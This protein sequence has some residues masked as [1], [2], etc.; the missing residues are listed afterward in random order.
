MK[1]LV[2]SIL[3]SV[4]LIGLL[5][6]LSAC[7]R[8]HTWYS[9]NL[10]TEETM[11]SF[12]STDALRSYLSSHTKKNV[13]RDSLFSCAGA[14]KDAV[15][16]MPMAPGDTGA[17]LD[18]SETNVQVSGIDEGDTVKTYLASNGK[19]YL[20]SCVIENEAS[21]II[22]FEPTLGRV[23]SA[24]CEGYVPYGF[25]T[26]G[27]K[28]IVYGRMEKEDSITLTVYGF[29]E[30]SGALTAERTLSFPNTYFCHS[31][32]IDGRVY[33]VMQSYSMVNEDG[34]PL[35]PSYLDTAEGNEIKL[36]SSEN[37]FVG[38]IPTRAYGYVYL[39]SFSAESALDFHAYI[40][41]YDEIYMSK[42]AL[43]LLSR[44]YREDITYFTRFAMD[45][46]GRLC[47]EGRNSI[48]GYISSQFFVDEYRDVF[49]A[50]AYSYDTDLLNNV[51]KLYTFDLSKEGFPL[52]GVS[53]GMGI[54][55]SVYSVRFDGESCYVTTAVTVDPLYYV[56]VSNPSAPTVKAELKS[57][58]VNDYLHAVSDEIVVGIGRAGNGSF[59][60]IKVSIYY[61]NA[62]SLK[63]LA[64]YS[65][66]EY[67][68][69]VEA[70]NNHKAILVHKNTFAF[71]VKDYKNAE[72]EQYLLVV[73][74]VSGNAEDYD[75]TVSVP[76]ELTI[77]RLA[78]TP[79]KG[80]YYD[81]LS[82]AVVLQGR[83][84]AVGNNQLICYGEDFKQIASY[85]L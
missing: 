42:S 72:G 5:G 48:P 30:E 54:G 20:F 19:S 34:E 29:N 1:K 49:R 4:L 35:L 69:Y 24:D 43:Y 75:L 73:P 16:D 59:N 39:V 46:E 82:R 55:E 50:V 68:I 53:E 78:Y 13:Y 9:V 8:W 32:M 83:M 26:Y 51:T 52:M 57:E 60:G 62:D 38:A 23:T 40:S 85:V 79:L 31:R 80:N 17:S 77:L 41:S 28:V 47:Y 76:K 11:S 65:L 6:A 33:V 14:M 3:I 25:Y 44:D 81:S 64:C 71:A 70:L 84:Y 58:G 7:G 2:Y 12:E 36:L 10:P 45:A 21:R 15:N 18:N 27:G 74:N 22:A 37:V 66:P 61:K 56:D 67:R 63:E